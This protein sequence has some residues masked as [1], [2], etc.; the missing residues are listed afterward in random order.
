MPL[1]TKS[2]F[3][4]ALE[5]PTKLYYN[6]LR[7]DD[8]QLVYKN[9]MSEDTFM[10]I[11]ADG[12][13][14]VG[15]LAKFK[16]HDD[17]VGADITVN[18]LGYDAAIAETLRK[19]QNDMDAGLQRTV[20]AEAAIRHGDYFIRVDILVIDHSKRRIDLIE[21]KSKSV[22]AEAI[23]NG[24]KKNSKFETK[25]LPYLYDVAFQTVVTERALGE[26]HD[27]LLS[28]YTLRP[29]LVLANK[30]KECD[31][32]S[33]HQHFRVVRDR[34]NSRNVRVD[35]REGVD[36]ASLGS[37]EILEEVD[38]TG[39]VSELRNM[40]VPG[41]FIPEHARTNLEAFMEWSC[42]IQQGGERYYCKPDKRCK[43]CQFRASANDQLLSGI[44]ECWANAIRSGWLNGNL[45]EHEL[46]D[47]SIPLSIDLWG[48]KAGPVSTAG[49]V[50]DA[51]H[52]FVGD[53][54]PIVVEPQNLKVEDNFTPHDRRVMQIQLANLAGDHHRV[55]TGYL[56]REM[57][58]WEWPL[59][60]IDFETTAPAIP[61][62]SGLTPYTTIAFQF[63]HH[64]MVKAADGSISIRHENQ[65]ISTDANM[66]PTVDFVRRLRNALM[67][68]GVLRG[69][70]FRYSFHEN[71]VLRS[72]RKVLADM[73]WLDDQAQLISFID[74]ITEY[75]ENGRTKITGKKNMVD[76][77]DVIIKGYY[78]KYAGGSNSLKYIL[79]AILNDAPQMAS[80]YA[81]KGVYGVDL[82][83]SSLNFHDPKGHIWLRADAGFN[84]YK[85]LPPIFEGIDV[86]ELD[87]LVAGMA[88]DDGNGTIDQGGLAMAAY[89]Y[90]QYVDLGQ[91][92]RDAIRTALLKYCE[93]DTLAMCMLAEGLMELVQNPNK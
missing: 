56:Q 17:P 71:T 60:M 3:K 18:E 67:P 19:I 48:G 10:Q 39:I 24:F 69:T 50:L 2:R 77:M 41:S 85:T 37:L 12:G 81:Q 68:D 73:P 27:G 89:N 54:Q 93:L 21:V 44:H 30:D 7:D 38:M 47:R 40:E 59:H 29:M 82:Q 64:I 28:S 16:Y 83:I 11:L 61:F 5:C 57:S 6:D 20:I 91:S 15:E 70:V 55:H 84:P 88:S 51:G 13:H 52:A 49:K 1:F 32:E 22:D 34:T 75:K 92:E 8:N 78:S 25:F 87:E 36:R 90:T 74:F 31:V 46:L 86:D 66:N 9:K 65:Y 33:L 63:S 79:P 72:I 76:L 80:R 62:F 53:I 35:V 58:N 4:L 23:R 43:K 26:M 42:Y 14:M 45:E